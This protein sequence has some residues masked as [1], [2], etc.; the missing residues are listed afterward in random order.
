[1]RTARSGR[2]VDRRGRRVRHAALH[3][4]PSPAGANARG[5][6]GRQRPDGDALTLG[7]IEWIQHSD[8]GIGDLT[9]LVVRQLGLGLVVGVALG[10]AAS[11][12]FARLPEQ[13]GVFAPVASVAAAALSFGVADVIDGSGFLAVY[14]VGLAVGSTP[15]RY[16]RQ[17]VSFH[18][19]LAFLA[20]V[21]MFVV[22]G[23]LVFPAG[24][25]RSRWRAWRSPR[26]SW[27]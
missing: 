27:P 26:C 15:S 23:L 18:E 1:M 3:A 7:L 20:Q 8:Y 24:S 6:D 5:G 16:R 25:A 10:F 21:A 22:L 13:I 19:G 4:H 17:L 12:A 11:W 14:I 2:R 9:L